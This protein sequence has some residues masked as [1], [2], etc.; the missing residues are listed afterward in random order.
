MA[1]FGIGNTLLGI[2]VVGFV[3]EALRS[4]G[5]RGQRKQRE[6]AAE[7]SRSKLALDTEIEAVTLGEIAGRER[8]I[9]YQEGNRCD[10]SA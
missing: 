9:A 8:E 5:K 1:H 4:A 10:P 7:W 3:A 6:A 2:L